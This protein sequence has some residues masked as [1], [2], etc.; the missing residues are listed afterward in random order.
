MVVALTTGQQLGLAAVA[1]AFILFALVASFVLPRRDPN[2]PGA[3]LRLF[4]GVTVLLFAA[5]MTAVVLLAR[6]PEEE[7]GQEGGPAATETHAE[8]QT[9][10]EPAPSGEGDPE[11]GADIFASEGCGGC[12]ALEEA[13]SSGTIGPS[14]DGRAL[15]LDAVVRQV[16]E[17]GGGMPPFGDRLS[18]EEIRDVSAF[19]VESSA[20]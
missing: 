19:V 2:F 8:T 18:D 1:A 6:E 17:G 15:E 16:T 4:V 9:G 14:L 20:S 7:A 12:H 3:R 5:M 13:G 10:A 11:A